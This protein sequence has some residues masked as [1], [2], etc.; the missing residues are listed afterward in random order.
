MR[1]PP[2]FR[3]RT[4]KVEPKEICSRILKGAAVPLVLTL[5][6]REHPDPHRKKFRIDK[7]EAKVSE[8]IA[9]TVSLHRVW[10]RTLKVEARDEKSNIDSCSPNCK[11][12]H[13]LAL[14]P[15]FM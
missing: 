1:T 14:R 8:V 11:R 10:P 7:V 12:L 2:L 5:P 9:L 13:T 4:E 15:K 6:K 3:L